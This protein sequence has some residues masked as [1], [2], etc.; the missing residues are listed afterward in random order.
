MH[1]ATFACVYYRFSVDQYIASALAISGREDVQETAKFGS[2]FDKFFDALNVKN[3]RLGKTFQ[4]P[5][6]SADDERLQV[7]S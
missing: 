2:F 1:V 5:Y 4:N 7:C 6:S 3:L